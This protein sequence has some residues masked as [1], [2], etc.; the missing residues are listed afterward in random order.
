MTQPFPYIHDNLAHPVHNR[1]WRLLR[2]T[3]IAALNDD[4]PPIGRQASEFG[5]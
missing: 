1:P 3:M 5:L 2:N 4:L